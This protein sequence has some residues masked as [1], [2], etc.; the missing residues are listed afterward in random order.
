MKQP[1]S[2]GACLEHIAVIRCALDTRARFFGENV[3]FHRLTQL[4]SEHREAFLLSLQALRDQIAENPE[5]VSIDFHQFRYHVH[6]TA[7]LAYFVPVEYMDTADYEK[8][9]DV[10]FAVWLFDGLLHCAGR[11]RN[12]NS[13]REFDTHIV[14][15]YRCLLRV[16]GLLDAGPL[17]AGSEGSS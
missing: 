2:L 10:A 1:L 13:L 3:Q 16:C 11:M 5:S 4:E 9:D 14:E 8:L 17:P 12:Y 7:T 15:R 6:E